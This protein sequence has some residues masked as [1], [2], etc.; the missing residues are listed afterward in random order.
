MRNI[1]TIASGFI[2]VV[3]TALVWGLLN[4][5]F[6]LHDTGWEI[7]EYG[8]GFDNFWKGVFEGGVTFYGFCCGVGIF[9]VF[10]SGFVALVAAVL[11]FV[12]NTEKWQRVAFLISGVLS[13][14]SLIAVCSV[15]YSLGFKWGNT[16]DLSSWSYLLALV[17]L[18]DTALAF[19]TAFML[20]STKKDTQI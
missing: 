18:V 11:A 8:L 2:C 19:I 4:C 3:L 12:E 13:A 1:R 10:I 15:I 17:L 16:A 6:I 7:F 20:N 14:L 9:P 5:Y